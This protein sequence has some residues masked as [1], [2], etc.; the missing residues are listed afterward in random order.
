MN[1]LSGLPVYRST[2]PFFTAFFVVIRGHSRLE[3][4]ANYSKN[5]LFPAVVLNL[6]T[7]L[8]P[9]NLAT[10]KPHEPLILSINNQICT[11]HYRRLFNTQ[12]LQQGRCHVG[13]T[14]VAEC[15]AL[16]QLFAD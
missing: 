2:A 5:K 9:C 6:S 4:Q 12:Q 14:P 3:V 13:Q 10:L 15:G 11:C 16:L 8:Q 1:D 7:T